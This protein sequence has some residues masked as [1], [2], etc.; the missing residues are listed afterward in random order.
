IGMLPLAYALSH[1]Q[2]VPMHIDARQVEEILLTSAQSLFAVMI[3]ANFTF[4]LTEALAL[5]VLFVSQLLFVSPEIR[6]GY[7]LVYLVLALGLAFV[8]RRSLVWLWPG[9]TP[10]LQRARRLAKLVFL[11]FY[12]PDALFSAPLMPL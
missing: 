7:A 6:Y 4:S 3:I 2:V 11:A 1:G 5:L 12:L 9:T 8:K 10:R